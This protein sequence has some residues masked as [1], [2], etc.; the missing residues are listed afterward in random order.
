MKTAGIIFGAT[1]DA[2]P[3]KSGA[4]V[5]REGWGCMVCGRDDHVA[6]DCREG[7]GT[8]IRR[9]ENIANEARRAEEIKYLKS[10]EIDDLYNKDVGMRTNFCE[11]VVVASHKCGLKNNPYDANAQ[12]TSTSTSWSEVRQILNDDRNGVADALNLYKDADCYLF[13]RAARRIVFGTGTKKSGTTCRLC[14]KLLEIGDLHKL[15]YDDKSFWGRVHP[16]CH[17][18]Y[19]DPC[20]GNFRKGPVGGGGPWLGG[21]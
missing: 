15:A 2:S 4:I 19:F 17:E 12:I 20:G 18:A 16:R 7:R 13:L 1:Y 9:V 5:V 10:G 6:L 11:F 8:N 21:T 3:Q 14:N